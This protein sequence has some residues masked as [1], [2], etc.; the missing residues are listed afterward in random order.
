[1]LVLRERW[2]PH[3]LAWI[4][5]AEARAIATELRAGMGVFEEHALSGLASEPPLLRLSDPV[6][7]RATRALTRAGIGYIGP[8]AAALER[9]YDKRE[10]ARIVAAAGLDCPAESADTFPIVIKPRRGSDS[11]GLRILRRGPVPAHF[12][13]DDWLRQEQ[14]RGIEL[15]VAVLQGRA[16]MPLRIHLPEGEPYSFA[17]KYLWPPSRSPLKDTAL[18]SQVRHAALAIAELLDLDWAARMDFLHD[19]ASGRLCLLECDAAP[20][21][22]RNSAFTESLIA[23]GMPRSEQLTLLLVRNKH[24]L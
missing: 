19:A 5:R 10:C 23:A 9:C 6:M 24:K 2:R 3:P 21:I 18:A 12:R 20:L 14:L 22:V 8:G 4:H 11:I 16:G 17:R 1:V 13:S 7:L 15:T